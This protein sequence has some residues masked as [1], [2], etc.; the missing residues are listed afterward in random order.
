MTE[1]ER[2]Q[3]VKKQGKDKKIQGDS[4]ELTV[5]SHQLKPNENNDWILWGKKMKNEKVQKDFFKV[6]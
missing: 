1:V 4:E 6:E 2:A 5:C 3:M